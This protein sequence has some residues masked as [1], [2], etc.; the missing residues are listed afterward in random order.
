MCCGSTSSDNPAAA[1][2]GQTGE[3]WIV[4]YPNGVQQTKSNEIAAKLAAALV[5]GAT[6]QKA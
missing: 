5:P 4:I 3:G 2:G 6:Y 1:G